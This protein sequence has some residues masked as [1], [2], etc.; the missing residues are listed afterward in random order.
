MT[1]QNPWAGFLE[2]EPKS[3]YFSYQ[4]LF[5]GP[6]QASRQQNYFQNQFNDIYNEYLGNLGTQA[7]GGQDPTLQWNDFLGGIDW[8]N[9]WSRLPPSLRGDVNGAFAPSVRWLPGQ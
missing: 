1:T 6:Y 3:A 9:R 2:G 7:Q 8:N 5:G 4:N